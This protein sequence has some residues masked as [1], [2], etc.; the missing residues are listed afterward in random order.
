MESNT[1]QKISETLK[2]NDAKVESN[3]EIKFQDHI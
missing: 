1:D 2:D 3:G